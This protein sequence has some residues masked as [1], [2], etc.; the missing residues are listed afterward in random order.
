MKKSNEVAIK[1]ETSLKNEEWYQYLLEDCEAIRVERKFNANLE[2][3]QGKWE[4][5]ERITQANNEME[6]KKVYGK[7][8][9]ENLSNDMGVST[10]DLWNCVKFYKEY[11]Q[12]EVEHIDFEKNI[13]PKLP[14]GKNTNWY[15]LT[16]SL[17]GRKENEKD[18]VKV[19]Y[20]LTDILEAFK[21][22]VIAKG[23][24]D[25][26]EIEQSVV[27]F[28]ETLVNYKKED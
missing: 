26:V 4:I 24:K 19:V 15:K 20:R 27:E 13:V 10:T 9:I 14:E 2:T 25:E 11:N 22:F 18:R 12:P 5:G 1:E 21:V 7:R 17:G 6:R 28:K 16:L 23:A 8:V 3:L